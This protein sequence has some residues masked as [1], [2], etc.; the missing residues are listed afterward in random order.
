MVKLGI[1]QTCSFSS[2]EQGLNKVS[3]MLEGLGRKETDIVCLPVRG[4]RSNRTLY[5]KES[6]LRRFP[7][8]S[9]LNVYL[10]ES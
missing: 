3:K 7:V 4:I 9:W 2:N 10:V 5:I 1:I 8:Y 6:P